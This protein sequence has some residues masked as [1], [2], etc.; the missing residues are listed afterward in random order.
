MEYAC[1]CVCERER[2]GEWVQR[3]CVYGAMRVYM[4]V[5]T[6]VC[7]FLC[8]LCTIVRSDA[9]TLLVRIYVCSVGNLSVWQDTGELKFHI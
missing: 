3:E 4:C 8:A 2:V 6:C 7:V 9:V 1:V 5:C